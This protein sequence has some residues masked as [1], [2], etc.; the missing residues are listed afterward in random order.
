MDNRIKISK[1]E[2]LELISII[3]SKNK[4]KFIFLPRDFDTSKNPREYMVELGIDFNDA[5][6]EIKKLSIENY[7]ECICDTKNN[8]EYL[9][10]FK[11]EIVSCMTYIKIGFLYDIKSGNVIIVSF[12]KDIK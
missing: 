7:C 4:K 6:E 1:K 5:I 11:K 8:F 10:V 3:R 2:L 9:Y 12:H